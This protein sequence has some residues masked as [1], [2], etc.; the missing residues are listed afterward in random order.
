MKK[1]GQFTQMPGSCGFGSLTAWMRRIST[2]SLEGANA[3]TKLIKRIAC[4]CRDLN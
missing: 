2:G 1:A 3:R 4:G